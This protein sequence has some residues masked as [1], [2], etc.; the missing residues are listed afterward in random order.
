MSSSCRAPRAWEAAWGLS[1]LKETL[2]VNFTKTAFEFFIINTAAW[3]WLFLPWYNHPG[4]LGVKKI[5]KK[6]HQVPSFL[7]WLSIQTPHPQIQ[8]QRKPHWHRAEKTTQT[9][10]K[11]HRHRD[12]KKFTETEENPTDTQRKPHRHRDRKNPQTHREN[13]TDTQRKPH[14]DGEKPTVTQRKT[15]RQTKKML[16]GS[17]DIST[18]VR[19]LT[20]FVFCFSW[21]LRWTNYFELSKLSFLFFLF[22]LLIFW[23][24]E[25]YIVHYFFFINLSV[26]RSCVVWICACTLPC[27]CPWLWDVEPAVGN[28]DCRAQRDPK[29]NLERK[30]DLDP[31]WVVI[32]CCFVCCCV[33]TQSE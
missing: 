1:V 28:A 9:Q 33:W 16:G 23:T 24:F 3:S 14:R 27:P 21:Y 26:V 8:R 13:P 25:I 17:P 19:M 29:D 30:E 10:G 22:P 5:I 12:R 20:S 7:P 18:S 11:C 32:T 15:H 6:L 2:W 4:W 31:E